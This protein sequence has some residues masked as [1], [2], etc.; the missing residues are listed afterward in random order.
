MN[1]YSKPHKL[2]HRKR[3]NK[4]DQNKKS[5]I[6]YI[7]FKYLYKIIDAKSEIKRPDQDRITR[8]VNI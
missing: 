2:I 6:V 1:L 7:I 8:C 5:D 3:T 4:S